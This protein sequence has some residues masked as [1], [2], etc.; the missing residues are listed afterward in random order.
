MAPKFISNKII[1]LIIFF[2]A[3]FGI[4]YFVFQKYQSD[5]SVGGNRSKYPPNIIRT[6][7]GDAFYVD[8]IVI[9]LVPEATKDDAVA[10][11]SSI[12]GQIMKSVESINL[13]QIRVNTKTVK[14]LEDLIVQLE[15]REDP[16]IISV[17]EN[18]IYNPF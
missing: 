15:S 13:Y 14:E 3:V 4:V 9:S 6:E 17:S 8:Q 5:Y 18:H 12:N 2:T 10:I 1:L 11:A 16:K 7:R